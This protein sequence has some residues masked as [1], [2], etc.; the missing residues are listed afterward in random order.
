[1]TQI[2]ISYSHKD[3]QYLQKGELI[4]YLEKE[5]K[6]KAKFWYD[7]DI[8]AGD[9]WDENIHKQILN[10]QIA[11]LLVSENFI[12]SRY[13]NRKEV[14]KFLTTTI[15]KFVVLPVIVS[16][17]NPAKIKWLTLK[18]YKPS[19]GRSI[20]S[21]YPPG[22][23][24]KAFYKELL[25]DLRK[26]IAYLKKPEISAGQAL[27]GMINLVNSI[28]TELLTV[29]KRED[30]IGN[31]HKLIMGGD[32]TTL[33]A[34]TRNTFSKPEL[35]IIRFNELK[36]LLPAVAFNK[37]KTLDKLLTNSYSKW[38]ALDASISHLNSAKKN[39]AIQAQKYKI[40]FGMFTGLIELLNYL[41]KI[42]FDLHDHY[43]SIYHAMGIAG[44]SKVMYS[45]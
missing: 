28:E 14:K 32:S 42:G 10:S 26:H 41:R 21:D 33:Y 7:T 3:G 4:P 18:Q 36:K 27:S 25:K 23:A 30:L 1:M 5:L 34:D 40:I 45:Y 17:C 43:E 2:F 24:R 38:F 12:R 44:K 31:D 6:G 19:G 16:P 8:A 13:I 35:K 22:A 9:H 11:I 39:K 20:E 29:C 37:I 15:K